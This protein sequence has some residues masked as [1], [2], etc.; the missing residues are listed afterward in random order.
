MCS[1][2]IA[3]KDLCPSGDLVTTDPGLVFSQIDIFVSFMMG[4][5]L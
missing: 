3:L 5:Q 1:L 2:K 4:K